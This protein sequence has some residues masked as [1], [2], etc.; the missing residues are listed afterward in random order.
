MKKTKPDMK[1]LRR[2]LAV[3]S[4]YVIM[5]IIF[6]FLMKDGLTNTDQR[7]VLLDAVM[8]NTIIA[9]IGIVCIKQNN[10]NR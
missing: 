7:S 5:G 10:N 9:L 3:A 2:K 6:T 1:E 4:P 8:A